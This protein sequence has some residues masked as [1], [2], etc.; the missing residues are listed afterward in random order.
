MRDARTPE[1][2]RCTFLATAPRGAEPALVAELEEL[3]AR[4]V[5]SV[6]GGVRFRGPI[7]L[8]M[9]ACLW[10]RTAGRVLLELGSARLQTERDLYQAVRSLPLLAW[11]HPDAT[12]A[13]WSQARGEVVRDTRFANLLAK[14][15]IVDA[16]RDAHGRRPDVDRD[17][18]N[19]LFV[20]HIFDDQVQ[21]F[22]ELNGDPLHER[23][24]RQR[25]VRAPLKETLA[26]S[27]LR[28]SGWRADG[29]LLDPM[30][31]SG[32]IVLEAALM[33]TDTAPGRGRAFAFERWP[34]FEE[35]LMANWSEQLREA[36][37]RAKR[38][39]PVPLLGI[40]SDPAAIEACQANLRATGI[41]GVTFRVGRAETAKWEP[42][43]RIVTNPPYGARLDDAQ[44]AQSAHEAIRAMIDTPDTHVTAITTQDGVRAIGKRPDGRV[45][46]RNGDLPTFF[47]RWKPRGMTAE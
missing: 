19:L 6:P 36:R 26:A 12:L 43:T 46:V 44:D 2:H 4:D 41:Q 20:Q 8:G 24:Y 35:H 11:F 13:V 1:F 42:G 16:V 32:T 27:L 14:D 29:P 3:G 39:C 47:V 18:P 25:S 21:F 15:A 17:L 5:R 33:A 38:E 7:T 31:G 30:C 10:L 34:Q 45:P 40:D 37:E 22:L 23:G 9:R 28:F